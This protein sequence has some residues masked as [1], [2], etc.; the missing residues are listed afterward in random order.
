MLILGKLRITGPD[1]Y[2]TRELN[3]PAAEITNEYSRFTENEKYTMMNLWSIFRSPLMVGGYLPENDSLTIKL[4]TNREVIAVNQNSTDNREIYSDQE[5]T[6]WTA[7]IPGTEDKYYAI[8]NTSDRKIESLD[9][10][11]SLLELSGNYLVSDLWSDND[12]GKLSNKIN[13]TLEPHASRLLRFTQ[14]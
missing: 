7:S 10:K 12:P 9:I 13:I 14:N 1:S 11:W 6:I 4:L 3:L 5:I 8:F 2:T